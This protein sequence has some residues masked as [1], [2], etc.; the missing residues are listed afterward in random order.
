MI[1]LLNKRYF[2][3]I[4]VT[5]S[6]LISSTFVLLDAFVF[7]KNLD[8]S[9][10]NAS[11]LLNKN[12]SN[13]SITVTDNSYKDSYIDISIDIDR[14]YN[15]TYY[16][17]EIILKDP[18]LIKTAFAH[19]TYGRNI[20][21]TTSEISRSKN[22]ILA[23]NGDFYGFRNSGYVLRNGIMYRNSIT[24]DLSGEDLVIDKNGNFEI[25]NE[26]YIDLSEIEKRNV[27][28]VIAFGP[29]LVENGKSI[30]NESDEV[31]KSMTS[32]PRTAIGQVNSLHYIMIVSD[33]RTSESKGLSLKQL[34]EIFVDLNCKTAYNLD[35][36]GSS[37][38]VFNGKVINK[39]T[40]NGRKISER[41]VSDIVYIGYQ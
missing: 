26:H 31:V 2:I 38:M 21:Q 14:K 11:T 41:E 10:Q 34:S 22:A 6:L 20:K 13:N 30:V 32:N 1:K 12:L 8:I 18:S 19:D 27:S 36:G 9:P 25:I 15:T 17:A 23:I 16:V 39:P 29:A 40:T 37:T 7:P 3:S 28:Q 33:G 35:G 4:F 5:L 24:S